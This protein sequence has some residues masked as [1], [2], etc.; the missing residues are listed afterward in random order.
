M[1]GA[2]AQTVKTAKGA[3]AMAKPWQAREDY[4]PVLVQGVSVL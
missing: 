1:L 3:M 2:K 4:N